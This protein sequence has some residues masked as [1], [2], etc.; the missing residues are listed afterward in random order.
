MNKVCLLG[1]ICADPAVKEINGNNKLAD[2]TLAVDRGLSKEAK[3]KAKQ[4]ADF[5]RCKAWS[6]KAE[7]IERYLKKGDQL[8][9]TGKIQ[10]GSYEDGDGKKIYTTDVIVEGIDFMRKQSVE[11]NEPKQSS[12]FDE[13]DLPF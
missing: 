4:T 8:A 1:R 6:Q 11:E 7:L 9:L 10:T 13:P 3:E 2:F 12:I 5:V